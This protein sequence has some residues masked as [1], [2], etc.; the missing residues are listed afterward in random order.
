MRPGQ[1]WARPRRAR[2][3]V[4]LLVGLPDSTDGGID[5]NEQGHGWP[6]ADDAAHRR[7]RRGPGGVDRR[8]Q[9]AARKAV[10]RRRRDPG[11]DRRG[12]RGE[13]RGVRPQLRP[14]GRPVGSVSPAVPKAP[15]LPGARGPCPLPRRAAKTAAL[16]SRGQGRA[17]WL[18]GGPGSRKAKKSGL[19]GSPARSE[20]TVVSAQEQQT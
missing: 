4:E 11:R 12:T 1:G 15:G 2:I 18:A 3:T 19:L 20:R 8:G 16:L 17:L 14:K 13:R 9:G 10:R 6:A 5:G 7:D